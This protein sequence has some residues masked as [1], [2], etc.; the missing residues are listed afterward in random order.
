MWPTVRKGPFTVHKL[1]LISGNIFMARVDLYGLSIRKD[2]T[3]RKSDIRE[4]LFTVRK[5]HFISGT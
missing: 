2:R 1:H 4:E 3:D 5:L